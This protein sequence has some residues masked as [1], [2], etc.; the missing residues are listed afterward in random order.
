[1]GLGE[2]PR[3]RDSLPSWR[4]MRGT[5]NA[6]NEEGS[7]EAFPVVALEGTLLDIE[8]NQER[9]LSTVLRNKSIGSNYGVDSYITESSNRNQ[10]KIYLFTSSSSNPV[11]LINLEVEYSAL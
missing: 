8:V 5:G 7:S 2:K 4:I 9:G 3:R 6:T 11:Q 1:L 10:R